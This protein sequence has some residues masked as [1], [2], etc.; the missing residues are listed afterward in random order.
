M[1]VK[2]FLYPYD[3]VT[4]PKETRT[5]Q[6]KYDCDCVPFFENQSGV[7]WDCNDLPVY[8]AFRIHQPPKPGCVSTPTSYP[9][10]TVAP[11]ISRSQFFPATEEKFAWNSDS[12]PAASQLMPDLSA[13]NFRIPAFGSGSTT[14]TTTCMQQRKMKAV[15]Q[16]LAGSSFVATATTSPDNFKKTKYTLAPKKE[17]NRKLWKTIL[18]ENLKGNLTSQFVLRKNAFENNQKLCFIKIQLLS[19]FHCYFVLI[20]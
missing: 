9:S 3:I 8:G 12:L 19:Q 20:L 5:I 11:E 7:V 18:L 14:A 2:H 16:L 10:A 15:E 13:T 1:S 6:Y 17:D 4:L